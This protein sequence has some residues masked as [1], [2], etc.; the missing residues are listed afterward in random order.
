MAIRFSE[1]RR[2]TSVVHTEDTE[3]LPC[4]MALGHVADTE[5][6]ALPRLFLVEGLA[7]P[8]QR[9]LVGSLSPTAVEEHGA[10]FPI[11]IRVVVV[12]RGIFKLEAEI[13]GTGF[14]PRLQFLIE[15]ATLDAAPPIEGPLSGRAG[16]VAKVRSGPI[17]PVGCRSGSGRNVREG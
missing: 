1:Q 3:Q 8:V 9:R 7:H 13:F 2:L 16:H 4:M 10:G 11:A 12:A 6:H 5:Q 14:E 15:E 17:L